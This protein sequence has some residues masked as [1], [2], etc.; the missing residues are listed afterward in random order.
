MQS[1]PIDQVSVSV[2]KS[3]HLWMRHVTYEWVTSH[4]NTG[5]MSQVRES[6]ILSKRRPTL[7]LC[8]MSHV[9][10]E[11]VITYECVT[12]HMNASCHAWTSHVTYECVTSQMS[13]ITVACVTSQM[14]ESRHI[15]MKE[16]C[17]R[18]AIWI[19][20]PN[21]DE[22]S[23]SVEWAFAKETYNFRGPTNRSHPICRHTD[24]SCHITHS[25]HHTFGTSHIRDVRTCDLRVISV[26]L[27]TSS[28][29]TYECVTSH[30]NESRH[31][32]TQEWC[33]KNVYQT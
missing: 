26:C 14:N 25:G 1:H 10:Y 17:Q 6:N 13:H 24:I 19:Y 22:V 31:I 7:G 4:M 28:H 27:S 30:M 11:C 8:W 12:S 23:A 15:R 33:L 5:V 3:R 9:T 20:R 18:F 32:W 16:S 29:A 21:M 2:D